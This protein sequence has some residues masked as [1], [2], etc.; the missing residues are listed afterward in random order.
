MWDC[1]FKWEV[2]WKR[3][4]DGSI[5]RKKSK[6]MLEILAV[7]LPS[8]E[9][10]A[11]P[12]GSLEPGEMLPRKLKQ[13]LRQ[14]FWAQFRSLLN[15]GTEVYRGYVDDPRNTDNAWIETIAINVHFEDQDD[16]E[17]EELNSHL[18]SYDPDVSIRW[19]VVDQK[20]PLYANHKEIL[21]QAADFFQAY[22]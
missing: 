9:H 4:L 18:Y 17:L 2:G 3:N 19:Q 14:E 5:C 8:S 12:G 11:L 15:R 16:L 6:K 10:W 1:M 7:K 21:Q 20:I 13:I 22:Y